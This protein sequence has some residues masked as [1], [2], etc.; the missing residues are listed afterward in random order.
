M[1]TPVLSR[2]QLLELASAIGVTASGS[3]LLP[4]VAKGAFQGTPSPVGSV[5]WAI[6][7]DPVS[8]VPYGS[9]STSNMWGKEFIYDSLLEWDKDLNIQP[10]LAESYEAAADGT[11]YLFHLRPGVMFHNGRTMSAADVKYSLDLTLNPPPPVIASPYVANIAEVVVVDD[12]TVRIDMT[13]S[14][15]TIPGILAWQRITPI[16]PG[17]DR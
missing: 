11:S 9:T 10:A 6:D 12:A 15:P 13:K 5:S 1:I 16:F 14:D 3:F 17:R 8:L 4:R 2:R 7:T